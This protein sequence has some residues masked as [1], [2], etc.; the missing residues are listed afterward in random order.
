MPWAGPVRVRTASGEV[1]TEP[2]LTYAQRRDLGKSSRRMVSHK[3]KQA[4]RDR[5]KVCQRCGTDV[6][7]FHVDHIRPYSKGGWQ[8][9]RNLQL[10]CAPCNL[11][12]GAAWSKPAKGNA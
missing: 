1:R 12:K 9:L 8:D 3:V 4:V 10:L 6:G 11:R 7:P 2:A 5:D